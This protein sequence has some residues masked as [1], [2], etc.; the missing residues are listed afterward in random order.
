MNQPDPRAPVSVKT[1]PLQASPY[2]RQLDGGFRWLRFEWAL[3]EPY[4]RE[5]FENNAPRLRWSLLLAMTLMAVV[6]LLDTFVV[7][8]TVSGAIM[9]WRYGVLAPALLL[10]YLSSFLPDG[11]RWYGH[12]VTVLGTVVLTA[13]TVLV[14]NIDA[15]GNEAI[16]GV[17]VLAIIFIY[18]LVGLPIYG[19]LV[20]NLAGVVTFVISA[21]VFGLAPTIAIYQLA[22][23]LF[24]SVVGVMLAHKLEWL[25]RKTWLEQRM[26]EEMAERD[27]LTGIYNRRRLETHMRA[28][29]E[30]GTRDVRPVAL[31]MIDVDSFKPYNDRYG[32]QA[33]DEALKQVANVLAGAARRPLDMAARYGGEEFV[34]VLYDTTHD[35]ATGVANRILQDVR[36]CGIPHAASTASDVLTV[37][38]G[39]AHVTPTV[40]R[41]MEGLMQIADQGVY[42]AKDSGGDRVEVMSQAEY[43]QMRTGLF[44]RK[45]PQEG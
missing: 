43:A 16:Y 3:E 44:D 40:S 41:S 26:L 38:I 31:L 45:R 12:I 22:I 6:I 37:S 17:L 7:H 9:I 15:Q 27:G 21:N 23:L 2:R 11:W 10:A 28:V 13:V 42:I 39:L 34:V 32:H 29:W 24:A 1:D 14:V 20:A 4:R 25:Q 8:A 33:G 19:A 35:H 30:Q 36:Q 18:Y 5:S